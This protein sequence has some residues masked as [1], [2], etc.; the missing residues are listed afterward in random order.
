MLSTTRRVCYVLDMTTP[1]MT[2]LRDAMIITDMESHAP[3]DRTGAS[4]DQP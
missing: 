3:T 4:D 1:T 2:P